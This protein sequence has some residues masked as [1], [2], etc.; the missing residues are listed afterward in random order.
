MS[1]GMNDS[2]VAPDQ[3]AGDGLFTGAGHRHAVGRLAHRDLVSGCSNP[4]NVGDAYPRFRVHRALNEKNRAA[5]LAAPGHSS[6]IP[7][8]DHD[9]SASRRLPSRGCK[10]QEADVEEDRLADR[11]PGE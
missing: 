2:G 5:S 10:P 11:V 1:A 4:L 9:P 3:F 6:G 8:S 7:R